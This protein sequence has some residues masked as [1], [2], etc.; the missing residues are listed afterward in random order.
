MN[1]SLVILGITSLV[2][3]RFT[4]SLFNDPEGPNLLVVAVLATIIYSVSLAV[5]LTTSSLH[6]STRLGLGLFVQVLLV[7]GLYLINA[8]GII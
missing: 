1:Y 3:S 8:N 4:F 6:V 2:S 7:V 5:Y